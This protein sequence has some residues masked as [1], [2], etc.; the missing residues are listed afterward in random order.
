MKRY[1]FS[2]IEIWGIV[3]LEIFY[4]YRYKSLEL[5]RGLKISEVYCEYYFVNIY[6]LENSIKNLLYICVCISYF[7]VVYRVISFIGYLYMDK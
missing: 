1:C 5:C 4:F 6:R 3:R 7:K 2:K